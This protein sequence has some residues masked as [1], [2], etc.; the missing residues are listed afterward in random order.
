MM[1]EIRIHFRHLMLYESRK[2]SS[3]IIATNNI[4]TAL[5]SRN[6]RKWFTR[7]KDENFCL[8][9]EERSQTQKDKIQDLVEKSLNLSVHEMSNIL[10]IP[11]TT[12]HAH[13]KTL[14]YGTVQKTARTYGMT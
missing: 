8:E 14:T 11:K 3:V 6:C 12:I 2:G 7:F 13:L 4:C 9:D 5:S 10:E 1:S